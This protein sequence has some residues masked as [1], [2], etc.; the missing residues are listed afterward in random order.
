MSRVFQIWADLRGSFWFL[1]S[2]IIAGSIALA[3]GL[4][5][6]DILVDSDVINRWPRVFVASPDG[7]RSVLGTIAGSMVT[8]AGVVFSITL[9]VLSLASSQYSSRVL[10]N[11]MLDRVNQ[12]VL[13]IFLGIFVYCLVVLRI[14][15]T[16]EGDEFVPSIAILGGL[17]LGVFGICVLIYYIHH[18]SRSIQASQIVAVVY[19]ETLRSVESLFPEDL[20]DEEPRGDTDEAEPEWHA[21]PAITTGYVRRLAGESLLELASKNNWVVRLKVAPGTFVTEEVPAMEVLAKEPPTTEQADALARTIITGRQ[22]TTEQDAGFGIRQLVD[23]AL[24]AL[25]PGTNDTTTAIMCVDY[26]TALMCQLANRRIGSDLRGKDDKLLV[27]AYG[28]TFEDLL[29]DAFHQVRE[30][31]EGNAAML[32]HLLRSVESIAGQTK[33]KTRRAALLKHANSV[34]EAVKRTIEAPIDS[35]R[36]RE[37]ADRIIADLETAQA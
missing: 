14:V 16:V 10:R 27:I 36:L 17:V 4:V 20:G 18:I 26:L 32:L 11:F 1:P 6:L 31:G 2:L 25:S 5:E 23:V 13:G 15:R 12:S 30:S 28:P 8:V 19:R 9:V 34:S 24:R 7:A 3:V 21:I 35:E 22:R 37:A 33:S 29:D